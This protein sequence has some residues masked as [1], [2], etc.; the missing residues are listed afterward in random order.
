[1][2]VCV[3]MNIFSSGMASKLLVCWLYWSWLRSPVRSDDREL[4]LSR[5][6]LTPSSMQRPSAL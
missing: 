1:M 2:C 6:K 3:T 4:G 5:L